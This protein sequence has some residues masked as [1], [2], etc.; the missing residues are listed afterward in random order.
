MKDMKG[1]VIEQDHNV[2]FPRPSTDGSPSIKVLGD[3]VDFTDDDEVI[4]SDEECDLYTVSALDIKVVM[5]RECKDCS[6]EF[7]HHDAE[8]VMEEGTGK[9]LQEVPC[10]PHCRSTELNNINPNIFS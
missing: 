6:Q 7:N 8:V 1:Y 3:V 10:C 4:V 9:Q 2:I 5:D